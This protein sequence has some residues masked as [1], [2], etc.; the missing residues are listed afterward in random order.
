MKTVNMCVP[1]DMRDSSLSG[2]QLKLG[3]YETL[4]SLRMHVYL[5][6]VLKWFF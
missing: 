6:R 1:V 5:H 2:F 4:R 3:Y